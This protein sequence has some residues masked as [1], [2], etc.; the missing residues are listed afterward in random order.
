M[1]SQEFPDKKRLPTKQDHTHDTM[2]PENLCGNCWS[3]VVGVAIIG[4]LEPKNAEV[5]FL[6]RL[7]QVFYSAF[8]SILNPIS[9]PAAF[10]PLIISL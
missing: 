1:M 8:F 3:K 7:R 10:P 5:F 9:T 2:S 4:S 6:L